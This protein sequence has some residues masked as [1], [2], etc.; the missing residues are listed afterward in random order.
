MY[1]KSSYIAVI[2]S[3]IKCVSHIT[4]QWLWLVWSRAQVVILELQSVSESSLK[5]R[6]HPKITNFEK[7]YE[8]CRWYS[9]DVENIV[10][11]HCGRYDGPWYAQRWFQ[12]WFVY[13]HQ[14]L[15]QCFI[16]DSDTQ[17]W[18]LRQPHEFPIVLGVRGWSTAWVHKVLT[19]EWLSTPPS[20]D[21][22][23][24]YEVVGL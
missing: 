22:R 8:T 4:N 20:P 12:S 2:A 14:H 1:L 19:T 23:F 9:G 11:H 3:Y 15:K 18:P 17:F 24:L 6:N 13:Q 5:S 7:P 16:S 10:H 21:F